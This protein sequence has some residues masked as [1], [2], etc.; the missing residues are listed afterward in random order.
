M[1]HAWPR[2]P[3]AGQEAFRPPDTASF[4]TGGAYPIASCAALSGCEKL[5]CS[6]PAPTGVMRISLS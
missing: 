4:G 3:G 5:V 6:R 2:S 1:V